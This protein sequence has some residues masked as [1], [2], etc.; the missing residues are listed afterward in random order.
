MSELTKKDLEET[1][2][3]LELKLITFNK[4]TIRCNNS[5]QELLDNIIKYQNRI[6]MYQREI[7][8]INANIKGVSDLIDEINQLDME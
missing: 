3:R 7:E 5:I 4:D 6:D 8:C 1:K 2:S